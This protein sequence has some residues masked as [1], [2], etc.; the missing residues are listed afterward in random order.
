MGA[1][2]WL[3]EALAV[4]TL[5]VSDWRTSPESADYPRPQTAPTP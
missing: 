4:A 1:L 3:L 5:R 2:G